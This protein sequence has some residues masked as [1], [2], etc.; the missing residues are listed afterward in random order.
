MLPEHLDRIA[1]YSAV[2][3]YIHTMLR[4]NAHLRTPGKRAQRRRTAIRSD[5]FDELVCDGEFLGAVESSASHVR[6]PLLE[7]CLDGEVLSACIPP[8]SVARGP[9]SNLTCCICYRKSIGLSALSIV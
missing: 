3:A 8:A 4:S 9:C 1:T 2:H 7:L 6:M 5:G